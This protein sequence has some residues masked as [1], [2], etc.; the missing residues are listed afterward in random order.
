MGASEVKKFDLNLVSSNGKVWPIQRGYRMTDGER[1]E[2][3][4]K[5]NRAFP[6][7]SSLTTECGMALNRHEGDLL[8]FVPH[9]GE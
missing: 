2:L 6:V 4:A 5:F 7:G 8:S 1:P 9:G 3:L